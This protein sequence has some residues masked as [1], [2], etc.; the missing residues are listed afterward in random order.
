MDG[1]RAGADAWDEKLRARYERQN[2]EAEVE[3]WL[4][5]T[6]AKE[7]SVEVEGWGRYDIAM[8]R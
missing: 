4:E 3:G 7:R 8:R 2:V 5:K 1:I 6:L